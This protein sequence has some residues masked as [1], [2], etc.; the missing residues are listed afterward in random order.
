MISGIIHNNWPKFSVYLVSNTCL[1]IS[2]RNFLKVFYVVTCSKIIGCWFASSIWLFS[3][4]W[5]VVELSSSPTQLLCNDSSLMTV[6]YLSIP[7]CCSCLTVSINQS[8]IHSSYY[9]STILLDLTNCFFSKH[10][11]FLLLTT[12]GNI[13]YYINWHI[14]SFRRF[15]CYCY[16]KTNRFNSKHVLYLNLPGA[17]SISIFCIRINYTWITKMYYS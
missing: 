4:G 16:V 8:H 17:F 6:G 14:V 12:S 2:F 10:L 1:L 13:N 3:T 7:P 5:I 9:R 11:L 15:R